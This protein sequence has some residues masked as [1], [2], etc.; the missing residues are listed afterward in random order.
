M[1]IREQAMETIGRRIA[2]LRQQHGWTQQ[3]LAERLAIS[4]VA[5]SHIE[6]DLTIP[7]E[8]TIVL[9]AGLF[10]TDPYT[11]VEDTTYPAAKADRLP[12][13]VCCY[14]QLELDL[15]LLENDLAWLTRMPDRER[16]LVQREVWDNWAP[17]LTRWRDSHL[18]ATERE[19]LNASRKKLT[20]ACQPRTSPKKS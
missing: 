17:R 3:A 11:L 16:D 1:R 4:R 13:I 18:S 9:L 19:Q 6:M 20:Q 2:R 7:G 5:V 8:R 14:T 12:H 10:K 15:A